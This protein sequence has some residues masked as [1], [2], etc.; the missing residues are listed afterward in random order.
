VV[1][2]TKG[3]VNADLKG[4]VSFKVA[5][6]DIGFYSY[7]VEVRSDGYSQV[8]LEGSYVVQA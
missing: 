7:S 6:L 2:E 3:K 5:P 1:V 8:T 4:F